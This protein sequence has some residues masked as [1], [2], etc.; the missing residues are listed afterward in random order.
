MSYLG[1]PLC[2]NMIPKSFW[3][4]LIDK[5]NSKMAGWKGALLSQAGKLQL[6]KSTFHNLPVYA[7]NLF[8]MPRKIVDKLEGIQKNFL[9]YGVEDKKIIHLVAWDDVYRPKKVG[10]L[11]I[12]K[13][14]E[15]N[16]AL[17]GKQLWNLILAKSEWA[18]I[19]V[20]KYLRG[21]DCIRDMLSSNFSPLSGSILWNCMV[22]A[23]KIV[24]KG[25]CWQLGNGRRIL[26][27]D[28]C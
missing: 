4:G 13:I 24:S 11:G 14:K 25:L 3:W 15:F 22:R 10:G 27:W 6:I 7:L 23:R 5:F 28:D 8:Y 1:L 16:L 12:R 26:F 21:V 18:K 2:S 9:S 17:L 20:S 19:V